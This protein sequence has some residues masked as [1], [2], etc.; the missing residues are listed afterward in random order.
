MNSLSTKNGLPGETVSVR[1]VVSCLDSNGVPAFY[2]VTVHCTPEQYAD[3]VCYR[4]ARAAAEESGYEEVGVV[5]DEN[6]GPDWL[7]K[8]CFAHE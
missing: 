1:C 4:E 3:G 2:P 5:Y 7:F 8:E 6:D